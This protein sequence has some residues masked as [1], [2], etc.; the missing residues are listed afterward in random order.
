M[1]SAFFGGDKIPHMR[2]SGKNKH[3]RQDNLMGG[4]SLEDG[5]KVKERWRP[6]EALRGKRWIDCPQNLHR[7]SSLGNNFISDLSL[8][9]CERVSFCCKPLVCVS[10][11]GFVSNTRVRKTNTSSTL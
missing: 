2:N 11:F 10:D 6:L 1:F 5:T 3:R 7:V 4:Q 8:K 9:N